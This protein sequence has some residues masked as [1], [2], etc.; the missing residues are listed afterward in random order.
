MIRRGYCRGFLATPAVLYRG[1]SRDGRLTTFSFDGLM[2][3]VLS[4]RIA[5]SKPGVFNSTTPTSSD[6]WRHMNWKEEAA[7]ADNDVSL[8]L[9]SPV[10]VISVR[11]DRLIYVKRD[12]QLRLPGSQISGNKVR[13]D[14]TQR[15]HSRSNLPRVLCC[16]FFCLAF[17]HFQS[18]HHTY[19]IVGFAAGSKN[20]SAPTNRAISV[21]LLHCLSRGPTK[22]RDASTCCGSA[23]PEQTTGSGQ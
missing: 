3:D 18:V 4:R 10:D 19:W 20:A 16:A 22:Q 1:R 17:S 12:D 7:K 2:D 21:P 23:L 14:H 11:G 9:P 13:E 5:V 8:T 15:S 6:A